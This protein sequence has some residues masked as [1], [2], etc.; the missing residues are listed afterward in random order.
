MVIIEIEPIWALRLE[1]G[2]YNSR[3][4]FSVKGLSAHF[5]KNSLHSRFK[6]GLVEN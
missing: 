1:G 3:E 5:Y 6:V 2:T 4:P